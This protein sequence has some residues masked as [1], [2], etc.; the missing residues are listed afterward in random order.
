[1]CVVYVVCV[2]CVYCMWYGVMWWHLE[3]LIGVG[4]VVVAWGIV[5]RSVGGGSLSNVITTQ[6]INRLESLHSI[7]IQLYRRTCVAV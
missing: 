5:V 7:R 3:V 6:Q 4:L 2:V 1:M